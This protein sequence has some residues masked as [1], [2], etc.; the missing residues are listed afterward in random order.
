VLPSHTYQG[1]ALLRSILKSRDAT[2]IA[3]A[4]EY[5]KRIKLYPLSAAAQ[6]PKT[7]FADAIDVVVSEVILQ[8]QNPLRTHHSIALFLRERGRRTRRMRMRWLM[9]T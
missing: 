2:D 6:P 8:I 7:N 5:G 1:Y 9:K 3:K 4:V